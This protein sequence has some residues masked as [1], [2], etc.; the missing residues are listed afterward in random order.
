MKNTKITRRGFL[1]AS[2]L[3]ATLPLLDNVTQRSQLLANSNISYT[4]NLVQNGEVVSAAHWGMIK[5]TIENGKI[6]ASNPY[7][8]GKTPNP[9]QNY[10]ADLVYTNAR[11]RY[12]MARKSYIENPDNPKPELRGR[13]EWVRLDYDTAIKLIAYELK[14]TRRE[15]GDSSIYAGSYG[16]YSSGRMHNCRILLWRF[17]GMTGGYV[18]STGDYST[19]ASQVIMPHVTGSLEVYEQQTSW[20]TIMLDT[21]I[22][23]LWGMNP[24]AT[25]RLDWGVTDSEGIEYLKR[26]KDS[27]K[28]IIHIDPVKN[29][30]AVEL[31]AEW[32]API[33]NTDVALMLGIAH[34]MYKNNKYD[35]DFIENYTTGFDKFLDYLLGKNDKTPKD[36]KW[37]SKITGLNE[38]VITEL[39]NAFFDNRTMFMSG[40][41]MQR[42]HHGEQPHWML[43]T[44][45]SM[46]GQIGLPGGGFGLSYHYSG[47]GCPTAK[48][49]IL[50]GMTAGNVGGGGWLDTAT[51][52]NIPVARVADMLLN[53]GKIIDDDGKKITYPDID[54]VYWVGGNPFVHHQD[55]NTLIKAWRKPRTV[56]VH[57][58][59]WT[60]TAR[61]ADIVM[62]ATTSYERNDIAMVGDYS[63]AYMT[64]MKQLV[65]KEYESADDYQI[66]YDLAKEF[67]VGEKFSE[68]KNEMQWI[69]EFYNSALKQAQNQNIPMPS[70]K[71]FWDANKPLKFEIPYENTE[72][73]K[74]KDFR[75]DP[76]LNPL[77]TP[78]GLIEIYSSTIEKM[79]YDDCPPHPTWLEPIEWLGMQNKPAEFHLIS[80]H[81]TDRLH[82]QLNQTSLRDKYAVNGRE[83]VWINPKDADKKGIK[84]GDIVRI[85]NKRG[86][87]L[88]GAVLT[89]NVKEGVVKLSEGAWYNPQGGADIGALCKN[90]CANVLTIDIP[91]SKLANGNISHTA[92]VNVEK[93]TG[94]AEEVDVFIQP[95][96]YRVNI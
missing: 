1:K 63:N 57:D 84:D 83:P 71:E 56:V 69:E 44:L 19:G 4:P 9:L 24:L 53:P 14:K 31:N 72:F 65:E 39:A 85:F 95:Q 91:T 80:S 11:I 32:I 28:R 89:E 59:Y 29:E 62:P 27:G 82:S 52:V 13:D 45:A 49:P 77:G 58:P 64:P 94:N 5:H 47:G 46:T 90:G 22:V 61:M 26:L 87:I 38:E 96:G 2:A 70:F 18:G 68:N 86:Q 51:S 33:P 15:K 36:A 81:P 60:P 48:A 21:K 88:A 73:I 23:V 74:F 16:W 67:G 17:L 20:D 75:D 30:T 42:A 93:Y 78:S 92:L 8:E 50:S 3:F 40:W 25:L 6:I 35:K 41:G 7:L 12:P 37:A 79:K 66:F 54:F 76:I 55:T 43:V 34:T 10:T